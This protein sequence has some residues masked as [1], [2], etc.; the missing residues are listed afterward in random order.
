MVFNVVFYTNKL[1]LTYRYL[2][3]DIYKRE[4]ISLSV[5]PRAAHSLRS[6]DIQV[7]AWRTQ[8]LGLHLR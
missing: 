3:E 4:L 5:K 2:R 8:L 1:N 7:Q 6:S